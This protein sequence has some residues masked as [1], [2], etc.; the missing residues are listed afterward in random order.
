[1]LTPEYLAGIAEPLQEMFSELL[2][3]IQTD[4][5]R[6]IAKAD[7]TITDTAK[8]DIIKLQEL[9]E[10]QAEIQAAIAKTLKLSDK[11]VK[12][13]FKSAGIKSLKPDI[14]LQRAAIK[15]GKLP[16]GVVPL[17]ASAAVAQVLNA[18][19]IRTMNTLRNLTKSTAIDASGKLNEYLDQAQ[20]M[21]QSG[22]FTQEEAIAASVK[23][24]AAEGVAYMDYD[25]GAR[26]RVD[27]GVRRAITTGVNQATAEISL[28]NA[29]ALETDLVEVTSHSD[30]RPEH[31]VWQGGIYSLSG[32]SKKY[33]KLSEATGYG[34]GAGLC[35]WNCRHSFYAYIE[36]VS[37][38]V[39]K[40]TYDPE[41]YE[42]EQE[43]RYN[44]RM[45]REWKRR[46][47]TLEAGGVDNTKELLKIKEWQARQEQH[48]ADNNLAR[49]TARERV[50]E[51]GRKLAAKAGKAV[52][53][54]RSKT[55]V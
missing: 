44:E 12:A 26:I 4:I 39:P 19:A 7:Y 2:I 16:A 22:A 47:A 8:W 46:A 32:N 38:Q 25:T 15:A 20:L 10:S 45:I 14:E 34:T 41:T 17:T 50:P 18:N 3:T 51:Y 55:E 53:I 21:V 52:K 23:K 9:G 48:I 5:A 29:A 33:R 31:A 1:M 27:A 24:L 28:S 43:Q 35:G 36:G 11:K 49:I 40:E 42:A 54:K 30:A 13:L 37:E 6:R